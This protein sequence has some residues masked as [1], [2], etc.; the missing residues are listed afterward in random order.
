MVRRPDASIVRDETSPLPQENAQVV[1]ALPRKSDEQERGLVNIEQVLAKLRLEC[2]QICSEH[3]DNYLFFTKYGGAVT[4]DKFDK[5][6]QVDLDLRL[7]CFKMPDESVQ[8]QVQ[9]RLQAIAGALDVELYFHSYDKYVQGQVGETGETTVLEKIKSP[10]VDHATVVH[11]EY[12]SLLSFYTFATMDF[13][14]AR[15]VADLEAWIQ[16]VAQKHA[17]SGLHEEFSVQP[18]RENLHPQNIVESIK[19]TE[20]DVIEWIHVYVEHFLHDF[21][22]FHALHDSGDSNEEVVNTYISRLSKYLVRVSFGVAILDSKFLSKDAI[23]QRYLELFQMGMDAES[24]HHYIITE[25]SPSWHNASMRDLINFGS[26][27]RTSREFFEHWNQ[28]DTLALIQ[29]MEN[30]LLYIVQQGGGLIRRSEF[31]DVHDFLTEHAILNHVESAGNGANRE[32]I[33]AGEE[34]ISQGADSDSVILFPSHKSDGSP[35]GTYQILVDG[36]NVGF[37]RSKII[38]GELGVL[39]G[40]AR[41]TSIVAESDMEILL[42]SKQEVERLFLTQYGVAP[43]AAEHSLLRNYLTGHYMMRDQERADTRDAQLIYSLLSYFTDEFLKYLEEAIKT[44]KTFVSER[45]A[46]ETLLDAYDIN[47]MPECFDWMIENDNEEAIEIVEHDADAQLFEVGDAAV[48]LYFVHTA[49]DSG[50]V[51]VAFEN[52]ETIVLKEGEIVGEDALLPNKNTRSYSAKVFAGTKLVKTT[53]KGFRDATASTRAVFAL[54]NSEQGGS[55]YRQYSRKEIFFAVGV[56]CLRR[57]QSAF[58]E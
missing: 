54:V 19:I 47:N 46:G 45:E 5:D 21:Q 2:D 32:K 30:T 33:S 25:I 36:Q 34:F 43:E 1:D 40:I 39:L 14:T 9:A 8:K 31:N 23:A 10:D 56:K 50:G 29:D 3:P 37:H 16:T 38:V 55:E 27:I 49:G 4:Q 42:I 52:G 24:V 20:R 28:D 44:G 26:Y 18:N 48:D 22:A 58:V 57:L 35:N 12:P 13:F 6:S 17:E 7:I 15:E 51:E 41:T 53:E 11:I